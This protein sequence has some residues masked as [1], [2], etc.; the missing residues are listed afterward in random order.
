MSAKQWVYMKRTYADVYN[1]THDT[2]FAP[3]HDG[4]IMSLACCM[5]KLRKRVG[6]LWFSMKDPVT[7]LNYWV[8]GRVAYK[9]SRS[10]KNTLIYFMRVTDVMSFDRYHREFPGRKDELYKYIK[11][12]NCD[13]DNCQ[14]RLNYR[15][16]RQHTRFCGHTANHDIGEGKYV[17][18]SDD[19]C[20]YNWRDDKEDLL[21]MED[22]GFPELKWIAEGKDGPFYQKYDFRHTEAIIE[23]LQDIKQRN[24]ERYLWNVR[25]NEMC[26]PSERCKH[27]KKRKQADVC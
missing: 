12:C 14:H 11:K 1:L 7:D 26:Q 4:E 8:V 2:N 19:Y 18:T 13:H 10:K 21:Y 16:Y 6:E 5:V 22:W 15:S 9:L 23:H 17:L 3:Y 25:L 24:C 20:Y 27:R